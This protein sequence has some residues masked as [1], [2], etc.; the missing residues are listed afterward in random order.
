GAGGDVVVEAGSGDAGKGGELHLRGGTSNRGM[1]GDVIIDAG[2]S[3]TQNSSYE[4]VIHIGPTSAS[5][6]RVGESA[7]K[8]VKTDVF[9]DLTV[10]GN[11]LTTNDLV[12]ASTYTSYVQ[13][14]TTQDGMFQQEVRAPAVTGLDA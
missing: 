8:Q 9:G 14:S 13:V 12:Y 10:H 5:F 1:G 3:T 11:L 6:V 2:D 7:N 4:G